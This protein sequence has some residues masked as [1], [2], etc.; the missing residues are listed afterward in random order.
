MTEQKNV[1]MNQETDQKQLQKSETQYR[2]TFIRKLFEEKER[3]IE[4]C[5]AVTDSNYSLD[6]RVIVCDLD[7]SLT[8]RYN[9]LAFAIDDQLL[10]MIEHQST[11]SP[12]LP[13]RF[14]S[15]VTDILYAWFVQVKELYKKKL[16]Q[17]PSPKLYVLYNGDEPLKVT[18]LKL[19]DAFY[20]KDEQTS[21]ELTIE[22]IDLNYQSQHKVLEKSKSLQGYSYLIEQIRMHIASGYSRDEAIGMAIDLCIEAEVLSEFLKQHYQEVAKMINLQYDQ[23]VEYR[24]IREEERIEG[25]KEGE[26]TKAIEIA[27][28][29][30]SDRMPFEMIAQYTGLELE[31]IK[32]LAKEKI[33]D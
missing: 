21:L 3:V 32:V 33:S 31:D 24:A 2:D 16:Y 25:R 22:V 5:N 26:Q 6:T 9:D 7:N 14:L 18:Q 27:K 15:Y 23:E 4:L 10:F 13:L 8:R 20:F 30:L 28:K 1:L 29:L 19:S 17:I 11:I 12:N